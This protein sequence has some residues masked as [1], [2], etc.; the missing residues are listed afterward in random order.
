[1]DYFNAVLLVDDDDATNFY[2]E[3][4]LEEWGKAK[5]TYVAL[6][7]KLAIDFLKKHD[8]FRHERPSLILLDVNMP[9]MNGFEFLEAYRTL[10]EELKA[11]FVVVMLTTSLHP[12]D[13]DR[14]HDFNELRGYIN[15][16]LS[17]EQLDDILQQAQLM[18]NDE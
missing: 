11:S 17:M 5:K 8:S 7:G 15:K 10:D 16:P 1:M 12:N 18:M 13:Q 4:V 3:I 2:H 14:A 9:V 6:N